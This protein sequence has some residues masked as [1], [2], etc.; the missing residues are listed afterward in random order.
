MRN[1]LQRQQHSTTFNNLLIFRLSTKHI[2]TPSIIMSDQKSH[3]GI[4]AP[5]YTEAE[6]N[7]DNTTEDISNKA[8]GHKL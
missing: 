4:T 3:Q 1:T 7:I 5:G 2:Q 6:Q 8:Q